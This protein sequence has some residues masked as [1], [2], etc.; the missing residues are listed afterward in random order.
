MVVQKITAA[1]ERR[2]GRMIQFSVNCEPLP[3]PRPR[4]SKFGVYEPKK[5]SEYKAK[6]K[7]AAKLAM[8]GL[9]PIT[10]AIR[11]T[12]KLYRKFVATSRRFGDF[13]NH[14]KAI[15]DALNKICYVDDSQVVSCTVEKYTDKLNPRVEV[16]VEEI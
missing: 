12:I 1:E 7:Q 3:Q 13:D 2:V 4:F 6:I 14:G 8:A 10:G 9:N 15:C 5:I 16:E 11:M